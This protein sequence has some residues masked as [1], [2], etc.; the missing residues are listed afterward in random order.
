MQKTLL[1]KALI[2]FGLMLIIG[3]PLLMIQETIKERMEFRQEAVNSIAAD[4]VRE[5]T[6]IGPILVI[7]YTEQYEERVEVAKGDDKEAKSA[8][9]SELLRRTVQRRLL[10]YPNNL[11][12]NG[13]IDTDRR[14]R[15]IH[16]VLVYSGQHA[17]KGDFTVPAGS[18]LPRKSPDSRV[19][20]GAP[21]VALSIEDVRGIRNIPK[22]DWGGQKIEFEQGTDLF[23]F[24]SGLHAPLGAMPLT[25][26]QQVH[27]SFDLGLDG[28]ERQHFVPVAKNS[29][30]SIKSNWPHPQFGGRFLPSPKFRQINAD[31]FQVEWSISSLATNAQTQLS[32]IEGEF[33]VPDSAPL[34]QID[35][36][37]VG[38][39]EP[40]NVY[41]QSD[42][43]T[44]YGLLFVA[45]TFA[46]FFI[47]EI[48]KSLPIH[49]VQ[50]L[51]VGLSLV[52]FFL[53][54]VGLAEHIA[55][56]TAYLIASAACIVLTSFYLVHVLHNAW[57]GIGFG[58]GL[59]MLY[60]AL[61]GLL[62]SENNALVMGSILLFAVLAAIMVATRKVDWYQI[63]KGA[64]QE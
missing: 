61:Y 27:F 17:F 57:R 50:Y 28:I 44:K 33:K 29:Q 47:F 22:I 8:V 41:S 2:V 34:G 20:L 6:I 15:G 13:N 10:V 36:F 48:L 26:P 4:S 38:F 51:L 49:P 21:F 60:G 25:A 45:L 64:P 35:R 14:Y 1:V 11:L 32:T 40:V 43:A 62:S 9:R 59:T 63:G 31:G 54:L 52:I 24:R 30:I 56:L 58:V 18:Q 53:L 23:A 55:F 3:L 46:A 42:R 5:Q 19:T 12:L 37:S 39:I 16:Q 7:P